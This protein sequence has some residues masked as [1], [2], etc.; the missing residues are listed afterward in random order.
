MGLDLRIYNGSEFGARTRRGHRIYFGLELGYDGAGVGFKLTDKISGPGGH[1][2]IR[3]LHSALKP[4]TRGCQK[5]WF[6]GSLSLWHPKVWR[7]V[8][9][10]F[11]FK[12]W[13]QALRRRLVK[14]GRLAV[15]IRSVC[16]FQLSQA[17]SKARGR[18]P[19]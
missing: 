18:W 16:G 5:P 17:G 9:V 6:A 19:P 14:A 11:P 10:G 4:K 12:G 13:L 2:N 1:A 8:C 15:G 7:K 3:S